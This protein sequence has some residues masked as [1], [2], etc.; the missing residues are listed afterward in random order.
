VVRFSFY[1]EIEKRGFI[2]VHV[3]IDFLNQFKCIP[4]VDEGLPEPIHIF[5]FEAAF[6]RSAN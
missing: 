4:G 5:C 6:R 2:Q 1:R 3:F